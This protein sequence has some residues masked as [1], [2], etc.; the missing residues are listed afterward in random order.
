MVGDEVE[1]E[2]KPLNPTRKSFCIHASVFYILSELLILILFISIFALSP[3]LS[4]P[5]WR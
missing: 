3:A 4:L 1:P 2:L 5:H